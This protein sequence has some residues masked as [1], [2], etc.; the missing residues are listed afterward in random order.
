LDKDY[1]KSALK[2]EL[3]GYFISTAEEIGIVS[4]KTMSKE[5]KIETYL[6]YLNNFFI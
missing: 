6:G 5:K 1:E 2:R 3:I 4:Q